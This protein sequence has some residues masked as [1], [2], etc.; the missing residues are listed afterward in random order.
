[1]QIERH[2]MPDGSEELRKRLFTAVT[3][4]DMTRQLRKAYNKARSEPTLKEIRQVEFD[5][6][7]DLCPCGSSRLAKNCCAARL[8]KRLAAQRKAAGVAKEEE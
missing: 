2:E 8:V 3:P 6:E 5:P 1:M 4:E 7:N